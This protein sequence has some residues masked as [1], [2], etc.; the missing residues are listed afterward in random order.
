MTSSYFS[1][2][3]I[4]YFLEISSL[5]FSWCS[6]NKNY[7]VC[8][9]W[10]CVVKFFIS[11]LLII[12]EVTTFDELLSS[13][14]KNGFQFVLFFTKS[15]DVF[16][17]EIR[18]F[19]FLATKTSFHFLW[20]KQILAKNWSYFLFKRGYSSFNYNTIKALLLKWF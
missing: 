11:N 16:F 7:Y 18:F 1:S 8:V 12:T 5:A 17:N 6:V 4:D 10:L 13:V 3:L 9:F 15:Y 20:I 19:I 14:S 2:S